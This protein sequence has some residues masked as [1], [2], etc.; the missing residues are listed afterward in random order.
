MSI[1]EIKNLSYK[2]G[3]GTPFEIAALDN[4]NI[5]VEKGEMLRL[6]AIQ[7]QV[8]QHLYSISMHF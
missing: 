4:I 6:S 5:S 7:A 2:Y 8:N 1:L 3:V